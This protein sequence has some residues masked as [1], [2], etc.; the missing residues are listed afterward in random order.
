MPPDRHP[1]TAPSRPAPRVCPSTRSCSACRTSPSCRAP[2]MRKSW[3]T[4]AVQLG[5][6]AL[7]ITDECSLAG[8][9]RA[10]AEAKR[11]GLP[12]IIGA[13]FHLEHPDGAPRAVAP[14]AG[15]EPQR[16]RQPV[17]ADH[18]R[19]HAQREGQLP[20]APGRPRRAAGRPGAPAAACRTAWRSCCRPTRAT[21]RPTSTACTPRPRGWPRPS[22]AAPGSA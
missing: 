3:W 14:A 16:L 17:R 18:A 20:A 19:A 5:Y 6:A 11:E 12:L 1:T 8:V 9:V 13:H 2:R 10:H 4:R 21:S 22:R 7:A 15:A